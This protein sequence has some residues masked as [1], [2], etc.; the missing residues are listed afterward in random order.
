MQ[1]I[2]VADKNRLLREMLTKAINRNHNLRIVNILDSHDRLFEIAQKRQAD[3]IIL[4]LPNDQEDLPLEVKEI[5]VN[6]PD[7]GVLVV[8]PDGRHMRVKWLEVHEQILDGMDLDG[9]INL[10]S[11]SV[12]TE[13]HFDPA[14]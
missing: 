14:V 8:S 4:S 9:L 12:V 7:V 1:K 13:T 5:L 6:F 11:A 3:W 2:I 10:L